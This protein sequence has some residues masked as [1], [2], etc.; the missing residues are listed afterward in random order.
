MLLL[1]DKMPN[2]GEE[3]KCHLLEWQSASLKRVCRSTLQAEVLSSMVG[4]ES[5]QQVRFLL[6]SLYHPRPQG[7]RG[8]AWKIA[9]SDSKVIAW[10]TDCF[11]YLQYL[12]S[13]IP[14]T[15]SDK[16]LA[17]DLTAF[18]PGAVARAR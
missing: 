16:R 14:N 1:A 15:V 5:A 6:Y 11:S 12:S 2:L 7:D 9:A 3:A 10:V 8:G 18:A 4:S 13:I 17:I